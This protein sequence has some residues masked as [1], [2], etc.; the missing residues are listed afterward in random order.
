M[1]RKAV[2]NLDVARWRNLDAA[3]ILQLLS[4]YAKQDLSFKPLQ[5]SETSRWHASAAGV[6]YEFVCT[7]PKFFDTRS[8]RGGY[9]AIDLAMYLF[10]LDFKSATSFLHAKEL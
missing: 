6:D 9:G 2:D 7:G 5:K 4:D 3:G 1:A 8:R 10:K